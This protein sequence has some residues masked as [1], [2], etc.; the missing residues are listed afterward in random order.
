M[1]DSV[2]V[3]APFEENLPV[4]LIIIVVSYG[5]LYSISLS[6]SSSSAPATAE[7]SLIS[8]FYGRPELSLF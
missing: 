3:V 6:T 5:H 2:T 1:V 8:A 7:L 4:F